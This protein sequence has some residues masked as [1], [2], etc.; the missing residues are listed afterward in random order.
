MALGQAA[1]TA[2]HLALTSP[3]RP[4]TNAPRPVS[5]RN[6][7]IDQLQQLLLKHGQVIAFFQDLPP[8]GTEEFEAVQ[9]FA[10]RGFFDTYEV[11]ANEPLDEGAAKK[12]LHRF[13]ELV[14]LPLPYAFGTAHKQP[15]QSDVL[16]WLAALLKCSTD[17][18]AQRIRI[19]NF[20]PDATLTRGQICVWLY[21]L[22]WSVR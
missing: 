9:F 22:W 1:G 19:E 21:R 4:T 17:E 13:A 7:P 18:I 11:R 2:A 6:V 20:R 16:R 15:T 10:V 5:V 3:S 8:A 14:R 12:M